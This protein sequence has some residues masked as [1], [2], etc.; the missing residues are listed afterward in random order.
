MSFVFCFSCLYL[1]AKK[2]GEVKFSIKIWTFEKAKQYKIVGSGMC[3]SGLFCDV[4]AQYGCH[5]AG[6]ST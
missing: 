3:S 1:G 2:A 5:M 4:P 6:G